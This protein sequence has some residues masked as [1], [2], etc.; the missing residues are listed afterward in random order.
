MRAPTKE[1]ELEGQLLA[2]CSCNTPCPC[3][4]G[5]DPENGDREDVALGTNS[6]AGFWSHT[7]NLGR[8]TLVL[9]ETPTTMGDSVPRL[10]RFLG[11][12]RYFARPRALEF[13]AKNRAERK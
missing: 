2:A 12:E 1:Y 4:I 6:C 13:I 11:E 8:V 5:E 10:L 3:W 9:G 7:F